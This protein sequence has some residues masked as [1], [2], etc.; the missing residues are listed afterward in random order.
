MSESKNKMWDGRFETGMAKSM[1]ELSFSLSTDINMLHEDVAASKA[2]CHGLVLSG[3]LTEAEKNEMCEALD[4][5]E[6][7]LNA[8]QDLYDAGDEDIHMSIERILTDRVGDLGKKLHSGRSRN[9]QVQTDYRLYLRNRAQEILNKITALQQTILTLAEEHQDKVMPGYTHVQ[10]AQPILFS[11]YTLSFFFVLQRDVQRLKSF[12]ETHNKMPLG[13]GAMAGSAF[14]YERQAVAEQLG[15]GGYTDNS[16]D[17]VTHRDA[18]LDLLH[19]IAQVGCT[20]SR[21][22]EDFVNWS[23]VEFGF[24]SL[25]DAFSS[26]SSM[27]PQ[28]K[29]PDSMELIRGKSGRLLG[30]YTT[31]F[32]VAKGSPLTYSRD[33]Q[34][35][36][37]PVFDSVSTINVVLDVMNGA[38]QTATWNFEKMRSTMLPELLATDLAD[39]LVEANVPF[40]E[41]HHIVGSLVGDAT[42]A[43]I[44]FL[45]LPDSRWEQVPDGLNLRGKLT[46]ENSI[47]RRNIDG[48]TGSKSVQKQINTAKELLASI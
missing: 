1:E 2:H 47:E 7:D 23:T 21:Y 42:K 5:I 25:H 39:L 37:E 35:D 27:M 29:N 48:G 41:A 32:T 12:L 44:S 22:A 3:V 19:I 26:G 10:Q 18:P 36:K 28:K 20:F 14:P 16:I 30:N 38:L 9:D 15:F 6:T 24:L 46:F 40:R 8:G 43:G 13:S 17:A 34:E 4:Q 45:A 31:L 11:H 33:L